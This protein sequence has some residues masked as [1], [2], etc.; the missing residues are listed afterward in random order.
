MFLNS[1]VVKAY[2]ENNPFIDHSI[3]HYKKTLVAQI[4]IL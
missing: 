2:R 1:D 4:F 3:Q